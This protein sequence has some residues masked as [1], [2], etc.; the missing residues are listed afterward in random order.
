VVTARGTG[1]VRLGQNFL[2]DPNLLDAIVREAA[3]DPDDVVLEVGG[4]EGVLTRRLAG[5]A[6]VVHVVE[7]DDRLRDGLEV[8]AHDLEGVR[9]VMGDAMKLDFARLEPPPTAM[10]SNLPYSVA[11]PVIIRTIEALAG[12]RRWTLMV[13]REIADR[14]RA[15]PGT[16]AYGSPSVL[17]QLVCRVEML[18]TVDP[19]V[20]R[21]RPRVESALLRL[22]RVGEWP[23]DG[24]ATLVRAAFAH[25]RKAL[26]RSLAT[27][28]VVTRSNALAALEALGMSPTVRA[29]ELEPQDFVR[30][31]EELG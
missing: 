11:T 5:A 10:V 18:R 6:R 15:A 22:E 7:L 21:P 24:V 13:Q 29:E 4:G 1:R 16:K 12:V 2:A 9:L 3:L 26:A 27:S 30:L 17:T 28:G 20:F 19:S 31:A 8:L 14:L 25:R 23:G